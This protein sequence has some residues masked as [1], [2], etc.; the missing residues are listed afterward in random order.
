MCSDKVGKTAQWRSP[1]REGFLKEVG[2][3]LLGGGR[4]ESTAS[5]R[6]PTRG[7]WGVWGRE[8]GETRQGREQEPG[9]ER[10][11]NVDFILKAVELMQSA[12]SILERHL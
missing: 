9:H 7:E 3:W 6:L 5:M 11:G 8:G 12:I 4:S 1:N 10:P 2:D